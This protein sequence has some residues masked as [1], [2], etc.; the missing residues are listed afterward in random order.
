MKTEKPRAFQWFLLLA[1]AR[2]RPQ[3]IKPVCL[4][5]VGTRSA[6]KPVNVLNCDHKL[7][8]RIL[9]ADPIIKDG[10]QFL[11]RLEHRGR[12]LG[13]P[14]IQNES[15]GFLG[16]PDLIGHAIDSGD[17]NRLIPKSVHWLSLLF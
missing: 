7:R 16:A 5:G 17:L 10:D 2:Y 8:S 1:D 13:R 15:G 12:H 14:S 4:S 3:I 9:W 6:V 11:K